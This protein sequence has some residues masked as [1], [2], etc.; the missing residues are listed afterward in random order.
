MS[1]QYLLNFY[2]IYCLNK[3]TLKIIIIILN[4]NYN[5]NLSFRKFYM[6]FYMKFYDCSIYIV[7]YTIVYYYYPIGSLFCDKTMFS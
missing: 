5:S 4:H 3:Q 1:H 6:K 2:L 7:Y